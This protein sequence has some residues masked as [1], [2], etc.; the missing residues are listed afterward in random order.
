MKLA[1]RADGLLPDPSREAG[2]PAA[3]FVDGATSADNL[4]GSAISGIKW[5]V[6]AQVINQCFAFGISIVLARLLGPKS[7]GLVGMVTVYSNFVSLL[8]EL[9]FGLTLIQRKGL[10]EEHLSTA[11]WATTLMGVLMTLVMIALAPV[12][13]LFYH[14]T[15]LQSL[16][17]ALGL[18]FTIASLGV[19]QIALL[20]RHMRFKQIA[21][22]EIGSAISGGIVGLLVATKGGGPWS[23]VAQTLTASLVSTGFAWLLSKWRPAFLFRMSA[24]RDLL[25]LSAY[26]LCFNFVNYWARNL[27]NLLIGRFCGASALGFYSRAYSLMLL[28]LNQV[29][30]VL[31]KVMLPALSK[32]QDDKS[33]VKA[34]YIKST[35]LIA[36]LTFPMM[37]GLFVVSN[38]FILVLLGLKWKETIPLLKLFCVVGLLQ[39]VTSTLGW[40]TTSQGRMRMYFWV[41]VVNASAFVVSF[42]VGLPWG[43]RGVACSY[44]ICN[45]LTL[46]PLWTICGKIIDLSFLE[47]SISLRGILVC[48]SAMGVSVAVLRLFIPSEASLVISLF[49]QIAVGVMI[50]FGLLEIF[51]VRLWIL[52]KQVFIDLLRKKLGVSLKWVKNRAG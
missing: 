46:Y 42:F 47:V 41:G 49:I 1:V 35:G 36:L 51:R 33:R 48:S 5:G 29:T 4:R 43:T 21:I 38:E 16:S 32:I 2:I 28:P 20:T 3:E 45:V 13:M 8:S 18:R 44:A 12:I 24:C 14:D 23:L 50:Y 17:A 7:Y 27:D 6:V 11:F 10:S 26:V 9:G 25:G 40:L 22:I 31:S 37:V 15:L 19:V 52:S 39:S 34:V 30:Q